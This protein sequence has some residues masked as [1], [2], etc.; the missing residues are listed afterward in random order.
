MNDREKLAQLRKISQHLLDVRLFAL[1]QAAKAR[2]TSLDHLA[3]LNRPAPP[4]DLNPIAAGEVTMRYENWADGRRAEINMTL[5]R[6][7][8]DW[9]DAR[10]AAALAF[11]R[12]A[13]I[14]KLQGR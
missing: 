14:G 9:A 6:Q 12:N 13:V 10:Q 7:T 8:V 3:E 11:G 1:E 4:H 5:A 2:Q